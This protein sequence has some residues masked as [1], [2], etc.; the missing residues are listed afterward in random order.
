MDEWSVITLNR[1]GCAIVMLYSETYGVTVESIIDEL[2]CSERTA[3][4]ILDLCESGYRHGLSG[5][6][7]E[8]DCHDNYDWD[9]SIGR[10]IRAISERLSVDS[11]DIECYYFQVMRDGQ[12]EGSDGFGESDEFEEMME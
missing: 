9:Y 1:K 7:S 5:C 10:K 6:Y 12:N 11:E 3:T 4:N 2:D 8:D